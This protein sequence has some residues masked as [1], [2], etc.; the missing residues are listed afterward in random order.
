[1]SGHETYDELAAGHALNALEPAEEL[2]FTEHLAGCARCQESLAEHSLV[3]AELGSLVL[4]PVVARRPQRRWAWAA[5]AAAAA[6]LVAGGAVVLRPSSPVTTQQVALAAC[7]DDPQCHVVTLQDLARLVVADGTVTVLPVHLGAPPTG[8]VY[9][10]WQLPKDGRPTMVTTLDATRNGSVGKAH[11]LALPYAGTAAFGL[12][13]EPANA[14]P[15]K[16]TKV[17]AVGVA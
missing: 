14:V 16:P 1:V 6:A 15:T 10:L 11:D 3:A 9:V 5:G 12:S 4:P 2:A 17:L 13:V 8:R 7:H